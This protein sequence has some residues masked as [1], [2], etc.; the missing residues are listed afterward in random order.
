MPWLENVRQDWEADREGAVLLRR[1]GW[2]FVL[3]SFESAESNGKQFFLINNSGKVN[4]NISQGF[5]VCSQK[6]KHVMLC[7][8]NLSL[9]DGLEKGPVC[10]YKSPICSFIN[11]F[12]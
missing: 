3:L 11:D 5:A 9:L 4:R 8:N 2:L 1:C 12:F 10:K 6:I 7:F